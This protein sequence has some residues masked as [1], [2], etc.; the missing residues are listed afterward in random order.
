MKKPIHRTALAALAAAIV[1]LGIFIWGGP[2]NTGIQAPASKFLL[3]TGQT[4]ES[5]DL[6]GQV[7]LVNFWATTCTTCVAE[8]PQLAATYEKFKDK[9]YKTIAVAMQ[10]DKP[11]WVLNFQKT[12]KLP[13]DVA[14]DHTG[15]NAQNWG[16]VK[17][18]PTTY[19]VD[20]KGMIVK[21][22]VG[23]PDFDKLQALI[24]ELLA[25]SV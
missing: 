1:I 23:A 13:F 7:V 5:Q 21:T 16:Q 20:K 17:L 4:L 19:L 6:K 11:E 8:M 18:T 2:S 12:R 9:G 22:Y 15:E 25:Q 24:E 10:Y 3:T 14:L